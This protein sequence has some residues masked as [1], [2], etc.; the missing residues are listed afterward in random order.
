M[1]LGRLLALAIV[2]LIAWW[3]FTKSGLFSRTEPGGVDGKDQ[4]AEFRG[5]AGGDA[6][7]FAGMMA[8]GFLEEVRGLRA[9]RTLTARHPSMRAVGYRQLWAH[10]DG[11]CSLEAATEQALAATRQL[12]KRQLTWMRAETRGR[13]LEPG[14]R[15]SW[16]RDIC[17]ELAGLGL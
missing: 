11:A 3:V 17:R 5:H 16:I 7:R 14:D 1:S 9:D 2:L 15:L 4:Y 8:A 10:L 12:A 13:W 6:Q